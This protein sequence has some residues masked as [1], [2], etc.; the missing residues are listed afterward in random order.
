M[1][2]CEFFSNTLVDSCFAFF[3]F[4]EEENFRIFMQRKVYVVILLLG[5][6][7]SKLGWQHSSGIKCSL[8]IERNSLEKGYFLPETCFHRSTFNLKVVNKITSFC[9]A[10]NFNYQGLGEKF[11]LKV[12]SAV[13]FPYFLANKI[14]LRNCCMWDFFSLKNLPQRRLLAFSSNSFISKFAFRLKKIFVSTLAYICFAFYISLIVV[15]SREF[16]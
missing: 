11:A 1:T 6:S 4:A 10:W 12:N 5:C 9:D 8:K 13:Y 16:I 2:S 15:L 7:K 3:Q 14:I